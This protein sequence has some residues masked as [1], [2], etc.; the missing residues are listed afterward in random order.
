MTGEFGVKKTQNMQVEQSKEDMIKGIKKQQLD[1]FRTFR[2]PIKKSC[3]Y[4]F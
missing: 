2:L 3:M 1:K 4:F